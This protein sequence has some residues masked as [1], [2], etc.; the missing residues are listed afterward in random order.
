VAKNKADE[1]KAKRERKANEKADKATRKQAKKAD[2]AKKKAR[3][4]RSPEESRALILEAATTVFAELGP[5][6]AGLKEVAK[7]A[8]VSHGLVTH[9]FGTFDALVEQVLGARMDAMRESLLAAIA[10]SPDQLRAET[11]IREGVR[12]VS[13]P[14]TGRLMAWAFLTRRLD[15]S[16][17]F[18]LRRQGLRRIVDALTAHPEVVAAGIARDELERRILIVWCA[19]LSYTVTA[20]TLW[21]ALGKEPSAERDAAIEAHLVRIATEG[22]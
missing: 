5:D 8:G 2:K 17:F 11:L 1:R 21:G 15:E 12:E 7:E 16:G 18:A 22:L 19:V 9:Y 10:A 20:P 4:R 3:K 14:I 13:D 6:R